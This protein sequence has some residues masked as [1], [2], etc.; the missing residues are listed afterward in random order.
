ML[1]VINGEYSKESL[2]EGR[3]G[4]F[5]SDEHYELHCIFKFCY[6][7]VLGASSGVYGSIVI[8]LCNFNRVAPHPN[9][10]CK[11]NGYLFLRK[12]HFDFTGLARDSEFFRILHQYHVV[13]LVQNIAAQ[14]HPNATVNYMLHVVPWMK[15][16]FRHFVQNGFRLTDRL[17]SHRVSFHFG[18]AY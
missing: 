11:I 5:L 14:L 17:I 6:S 2:N 1:K 13:L 7:S 18:G 16:R 8:Y 15:I 3:I 9:E 12:D 10:S 4:L